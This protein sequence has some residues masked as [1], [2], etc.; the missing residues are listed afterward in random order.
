[1]TRTHYLQ[2]TGKLITSYVVIALLTGVVGIIGLS[3]IHTMD[4]AERDMYT[5]DTEPLADAGAI[6]VAFQR[7]RVN[8]RGMLLDDDLT[9]MQGNATAVTRQ[10]EIVDQLLAKVLA[11]ETEATAREELNAL[12]EELATYR[13]VRNQIVSL[14]L[15][16]NR[17]KALDLMRS[18][19]LAHERTIDGMVANLLEEQT[20]HAQSRT[21][22]NEGMSR[23]AMMQILI[24]SILA[25]I[26]AIALGTIVARQMVQPLHRVVEM[27][28]AIAKG[29]L[30]HRLDLHRRDEA[31]QM[32]EAMNSMSEHLSL[33]IAKLSATSGQVAVAARQVTEVTEQIATGA[34]EIAAQASTIA[35][36]SEEMAATSAEIASNCLNG[37]ERAQQ[38][39]STADV[40]STR[41]QE[42]V[43]G[44]AA[45]AERVKETA[46]LIEGL[47]ARSNEIGEIVEVIEDIAD[48]TNLLALNAAI[49][50][51]RA[52]E[53]GRGFAVVADEVRALAERTTKATKEI[54]A[55]IRSIQNET[56]QAVSAI[57]K[58][59]EE[60]E[61]G[62]G[63]ARHSGEALV[64]IL[65]Q[66]STVSSQMGQIATA[67]EQQT[68][69]TNEISSNIQQISTVIMNTAHSAE[70]SATAAR[71][72]ARLST[73]LNAL[74]REFRIAS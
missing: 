15:N 64:E 33:L 51:A 74:V 41:V 52:G 12:K 11:I 18:S 20:K 5:Q 21:I 62:T 40:G 66:T 32:A 63:Q 67:A 60:V 30:T 9:R 72:L 68:A 50:A 17:D 6:G 4:Q 57:D 10:D 23:R 36:A 35:T 44:M 22:A 46:R 26:L 49:E 59:V 54:G 19:G 34:E 53:Q 65:A 29:D 28:Q 48:Q 27:A 7:S 61:G 2:I 43:S 47:G 14:A 8:L 31:G 16:Y 42:T 13:P 38:A 24:F 3:K 70:T 1:M 39:S 25:M 37:A 71:D 56:R 58:R 69:T 45:T 73:E 55:R